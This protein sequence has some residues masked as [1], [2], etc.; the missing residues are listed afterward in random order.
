MRGVKSGFSGLLDTSGTNEAEAWTQGSF[1]KA[2]D[3]H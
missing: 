1:K 3:S 2:P